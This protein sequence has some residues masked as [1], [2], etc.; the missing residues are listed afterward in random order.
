MTPF[1]VKPKNI[2]DIKSAIAIQKI[3]DYWWSVSGHDINQYINELIL[4]GS[5]QMKVFWK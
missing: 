3:L 4:K 1:K 2:R 5:S